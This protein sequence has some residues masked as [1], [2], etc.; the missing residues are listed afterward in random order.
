ML[1][2]WGNA[3][4][5]GHVGLDEAAD[6]IEQVA[7][8]VV[9]DGVPLRS[10]LAD[11][12]LKGLGELRLA[13]PAPG[14]PLGLSGPPP[15]NAAAIDA[16]EAAIAVLPQGN[17]G[18]V[19]F[20]DVRGSSYSGVGFAVHQAGPARADLPSVREAE[21]ELAAVMRAATEALDGVGGPGGAWPSR[22]PDGELAPG[23]PARAHRLQALAARLAA[24]LRLAGRRGLTAGELAARDVALRELDRAVRRAQVACHHG[25]LEER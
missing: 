3:W 15:F 13:L 12:R 1:V 10:S 22:L 19:P 17:L 5:A 2:A 16:G 9:V 8:P 25:I 7:G 11:M 14:D 18:L 23:Y 20:P 6:R 21:R 24:A 4:L